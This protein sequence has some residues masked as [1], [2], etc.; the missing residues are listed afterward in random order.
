MSSNVLHNFPPRSVTSEAVHY[1]SD[2]F[3]SSPAV[4]SAAGGL[5]RSIP[6]KVLRSEAISPRPEFRRVSSTPIFS[7]RGLTVCSSHISLAPPKTEPSFLFPV[8]HL[9]SE[10]YVI[11][12]H[13]C[14][15]REC[16]RFF[17]I[18]PKSSFSSSPYG[19]LQPGDDSPFVSPDARISRRSRQRPPTS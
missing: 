9:F 6:G 12:A 1:C 13:N 14:L 15:P 11:L 4:G 10:T 16:A 19:F 2:F 3:R 7:Q 5:G 17:S 8:V 18:G